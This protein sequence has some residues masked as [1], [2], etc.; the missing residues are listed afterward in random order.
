ML[1]VAWLLPITNGCNRSASSRVTLEAF[2]PHQGQTKALTIRP[3][4]PRCPPAGA[5]RL[6]PSAPRTGHHKVILTW[7]AS[8]TS[9]LSQD[10]AVG[11]CLYRSQTKS[12]ALRNATCSAC[13]QINVTPVVG[14]ACV[15]D[16]VQ[17]GAAYFYVVT[18]V[19]AQGTRSASSNEIPA[20]IP[21]NPKSSGSSIAN[22]Y[23]LCR[24]PASS[25]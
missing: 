3:P 16:L 7:N 22:S 20:P 11:Y 18:A 24:E 2:E 17:D 23:P 15:D 9:R 13:E 12:A 8:A 1:I 21:A 4:L 10:N 14:T 6:Q 5:P 19:N 25:D